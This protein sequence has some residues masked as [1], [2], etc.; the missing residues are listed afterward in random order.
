VAG[1]SVAHR[2]DQPVGGGVQDQ[3]HLV[4][5]RAAAAGAV[6]SQLRLAQLDQVLGLAQ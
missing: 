2:Q 6:G 3:A 1:I 4:G 5:P